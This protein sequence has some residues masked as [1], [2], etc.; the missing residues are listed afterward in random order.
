[1]AVDSSQ[2]NPQR[3]CY[4]LDY[5]AFTK[6]NVSPPPVTSQDAYAPFKFTNIHVSVKRFPPP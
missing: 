6:I 2:N 4:N 3:L 5:V 1:M